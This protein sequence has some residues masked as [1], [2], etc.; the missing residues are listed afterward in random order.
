MTNEESNERPT[1]LTKDL[2][3]TTK[4][5]PDIISEIR[6]PILDMFTNAVICYFESQKRVLFYSKETLDIL[7]DNVKILG[8]NLTKDLEE[9]QRDLVLDIIMI[10]LH[11][12]MWAYENGMITSVLT[13]LNFKII[14]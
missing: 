3:N 9:M 2:I 10:I 4:A 7:K 14:E 1:V 6:K 8:I 11:R 12:N 5:Q 13:I